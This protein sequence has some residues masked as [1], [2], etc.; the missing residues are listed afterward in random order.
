MGEDKIKIEPGIYRHFKGKLY[1]VLALAWS[2]NYPNDPTKAEVIYH[3]LYLCEDCDWK[4]DIS[5]EKF[6]ENVNRPEFN[7]SGPRFTKIMDWRLPN[8]LP[9]SSFVGA[10]GDIGY[11]VKE[12]YLDNVG[13]VFVNC[14]MRHKTKRFLMREGEV[15]L[16]SEMRRD[17]RHLL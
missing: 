11:D 8:L 15:L 9:N 10:G 5:L 4:R 6:T 17:F 13:Q 14:K 7:Y 16:E 12:V 3:P 1:F 2:R